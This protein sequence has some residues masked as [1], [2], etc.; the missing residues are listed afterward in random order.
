M[1]ATDAIV[2]TVAPPLHADVWTKLLLGLD[3]YESFWLR[4]SGAD[5]KGR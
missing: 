2:A 4:Y 1:V 5:K 3:G